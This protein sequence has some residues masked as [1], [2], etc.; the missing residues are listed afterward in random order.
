[1]A[2]QVAYMWRRFYRVRLPFLAVITILH[3]DFV[4]Y[5]GTLR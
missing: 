2:C 3:T 5:P 4:R 1:M